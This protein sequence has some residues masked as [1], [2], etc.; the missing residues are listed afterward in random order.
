MRHARALVVLSCAFTIACGSE[1]RVE[2]SS[3]GL[4]TVIDSTKPDSLI[5]RTA[6]A[7]PDAAPTRVAP[8]AADARRPPATGPP[9]AGTSGTGGASEQFELLDELLVTLVKT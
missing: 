6:G 8:R 1:A 7:V 9:A 2:E 5:A 4:T 3:A